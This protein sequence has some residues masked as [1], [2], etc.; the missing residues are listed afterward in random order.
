MRDPL[1]GLYNRRYLDETIGRELPRAR[2]MN[3]SVGVIVLDIDHFKLL[4]DTY[5][6]DAGDIVLAKTGELLRSASRKGDI[7]CRFGGEEFAIV[8]PGATLA[9]A[10]TR[11]EDIRST[12]EAMRFHFEGETIGPLTVSA[13]VASMPPH[14][15]DWGF[16]MHQA[17]RALYT[18]KQAGRNKVFAAVDD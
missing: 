14:A 16:L 18:A 4:N 17:D 3:Q 8:L 11:A 1:T 12:I 2:R 5:G 13:G 7:A 10:R 9:V 15:Q 6:H